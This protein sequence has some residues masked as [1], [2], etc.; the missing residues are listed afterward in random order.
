M[1]ESQNKRVART[2][3]ATSEQRRASAEQVEGGNPENA[4]QNSKRRV[5][6]TL[7]PAGEM[8]GTSVLRFRFYGSHW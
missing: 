6:T 2:A 7:T 5:S 4:Q 8:T 1:V 3:T